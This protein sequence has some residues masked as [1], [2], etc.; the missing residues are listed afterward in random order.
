MSPRPS[1]KLIAEQSGMTVDEVGTYLADLQEQP[2]GS[3]LVYF[4][5]EIR[6]RPELCRE[7]APE[8][9]LRIPEWLASCWVDRDKE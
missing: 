9:V 1:N 5:V 3:W 8:R 4:G 2:D 7:L 6:E